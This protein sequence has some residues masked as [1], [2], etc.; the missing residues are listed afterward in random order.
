M[1]FGTMDKGGFFLEEIKKF[2]GG[3]FRDE[4]REVRKS[5]IMFFK[6]IDFIFI[7]EIY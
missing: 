3:F 6:G 2:E 5:L 1:L 7:G 4:I